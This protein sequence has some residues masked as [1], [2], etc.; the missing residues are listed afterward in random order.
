MKKITCD[1]NALTTKKIIIILLRYFFQL[2]K[3]HRFKNGQIYP[4]VPFLATLGGFWQLF[5]KFLGVF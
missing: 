2:K 5:G 4:I 1:C 3:R